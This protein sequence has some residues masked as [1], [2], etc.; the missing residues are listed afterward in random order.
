LPPRPF[1]ATLRR[2]KPLCVA[3]AL[4]AAA[5]LSAAESTPLQKLSSSDLQSRLDS[6]AQSVVTYRAGLQK[7]IRYVESHPEIFSNR[8][9]STA[10]LWRREEKEEVWNTW[11]RFLDYMVALDGIEEYHKSYHRLKGAA[12]EDSF[13]I[14]YAAML[15]N[16]RAALEFLGHT[17]GNPEFDKV[18]NDPVP[19]IGLPAGTFA[20]LKFKYLHVGIATDFAAHET[21]RST[22]YTGGRTEL[23]DAVRADAEYVWKTGRGSGEAMTAKN[24]MKVVENGTERMWLPVQTSTSEWMSRTKVY[25]AGESL[26]SPEQIAAMPS[27][28]QPGDVLIERREWYLSNVGLPGFWSHAALYIGTP[29]DRAAFFDDAETRSWLAKQDKPAASLE[30]F[31]RAQFPESF[32]KSLEKHEHEHVTR[33]IEAIGEGVSFTSL[34]HSAYCDSIAVLRPR[35]SKAERA[36][37]IVR[38]FHY[39]GRPY[40]FEF[41][42]STDAALVCTELVYKSYEPAAGMTGLKLPLVEML[43][44]KVMPA[45]EMAKQFDAQYETAEQQ[46][47]LVFFLDGNER[48]KNAAE[49]S[50]TEFRSTWKR[51]KWHVFV[52]NEKQ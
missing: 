35:L 11:Q 48:K 2:V 50:V 4:L 8:P 14:G 31:L 22:F 9:E 16:Y 3:F 43:G 23:R 18:L 44:R 21:L 52:Q 49:S 5:S 1:F 26:I 10:R 40:D 27:K 33:V 25:R 38:A 28:L 37:A 45:N 51:P 47:D 12:K 24:A 34:E 19:E 32:S 46:Y 17:D 41:D 20:K 30:E 6:D 39:A 13:L 15:A 42:F 7:V 29:A 36:Q